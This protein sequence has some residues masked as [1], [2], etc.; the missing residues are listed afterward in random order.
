MSN[1]RRHRTAARSKDCVGVRLPALRAVVLASSSWRLEDCVEVLLEF[2]DQLA[3]GVLLGG[4][5]QDQGRSGSGGGK[6]EKGLKERWPLTIDLVAG[7]FRA[8]PRRGPCTVPTRPAGSER[9]FRQRRLAG[10]DATGR[11]PSD[12]SP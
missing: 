11:F 5:G 3:V 7:V 2:A 8:V 12:H 1:S 9:A 10:P 6:A 4:Q